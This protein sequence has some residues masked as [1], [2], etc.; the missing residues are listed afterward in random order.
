MRRRRRKKSLKKEK[1][2]KS[3][4]TIIFDFCCIGLRKKN[5]YELYLIDLKERRI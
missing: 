1:K 5:I 4:K 2:P 3:K